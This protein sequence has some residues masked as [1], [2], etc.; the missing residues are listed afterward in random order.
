MPEIDKSYKALK[1][2]LSRT[3]IYTIGHMIIAVGCIM[4]FTGASVTEAL[5]SAIVEPLINAVWFFVLDRLW[6]SPKLDGD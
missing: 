5:T 3:F 1:G 2:S 6:I 4:A